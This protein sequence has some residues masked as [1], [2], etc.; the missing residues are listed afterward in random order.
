MV[1]GFVPWWLA[2]KSISQID[3]KLEDPTRKDRV[4]FTY[5]RLILTS[6]IGFLGET[7]QRASA[8]KDDLPL[9]PF[10]TNGVRGA[11]GA[12]QHLGVGWSKSNSQELPEIAV[13]RV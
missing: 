5:V 12:M 2:G 3:L 7:W 10:L 9:R 6:V 13:G 11:Q 1:V 8:N 4:G